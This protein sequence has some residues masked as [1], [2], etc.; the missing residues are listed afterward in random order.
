M[1]VLPSDLAPDDDAPWPAPFLGPLFCNF[2]V[3]L[4]R[5]YAKIG[6]V[7]QMR[8]L[9]PRQSWGRC[10][11]TPAG[12]SAPWTPVT[13]SQGAP[14]LEHESFKV[15]IPIHLNLGFRYSSSFLAISANRL[16]I[17]PPAKTRGWRRAKRGAPLFT[18]SRGAYCYR[19]GFNINGQGKA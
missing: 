17:R 8:G 12:G 11:Q 7:Q 3:I 19:D 4:H 13:R 2:G 16:A 9:R 15:V 5:N 10:P 1:D 6:R 14:G 18:R